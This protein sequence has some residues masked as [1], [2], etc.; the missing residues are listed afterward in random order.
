MVNCPTNIA[1]NKNGTDTVQDNGANPT[2]AQT[3]ISTAGIES[4]YADIKNMT[5]PAY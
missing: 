2:G 4:A 5:I 3:T 1:Q